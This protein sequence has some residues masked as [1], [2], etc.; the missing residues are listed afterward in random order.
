MPSPIGHIVA[1][2]AIGR[3][4]TP[5]KPAMLIACA[6]L[7]A[8]P[9]VDLVVPWMHRMG[10]HSVGAVALV[11]IVAIAVTGKVTHSTRRFAARP[12]QVRLLV[13][14]ALV[15]AYSS[16]LLLDW[17]AADPT[18]PRGLQIMWP[19]NSRWYISEM[20]VFR[21]TARRNIFTVQSMWINATAVAQELLILGPIAWVVFRLR[22]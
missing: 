2:A 20:D 8:A 7:A 21:G 17:L 14:V 1:G 16:H 12:G 9:D 19:F 3:A 22:R 11:T 13:I 4:I 15:T 18:P 10:T 5:R 6:A